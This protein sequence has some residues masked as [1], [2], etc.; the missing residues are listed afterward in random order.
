MSSSI[1]VGLK[2]VG[3]GDSSESLKRD[4]DDKLTQVVATSIAQSAALDDLR[5]MF[6]SY[7]GMAKQKDEGRPSITQSALENQGSGGVKVL[8][9]AGVLPNSRAVSQVI[10]KHTGTPKE[11]LAATTKV[12]SKSKPGA[13]TTKAD[14]MN[15][16]DLANEVSVHIWQVCCA[17]IMCGC[18][19]FQQHSLFMQCITLF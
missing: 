12:A 14:V 15:L 18:F 11:K 5:S 17:G 10:A 4:I 16:S 9:A 6:Q 1:V 7:M 8:D 13:L 2:G 19:C 3:A